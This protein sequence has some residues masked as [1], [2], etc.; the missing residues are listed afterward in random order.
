MN[1]PPDSVPGTIVWIAPFYNRSGF[2]VGARAIVSHLYRMGNRVRVV[3]VDQV[4]PGIDDCDMALIKSLEQTP[5]VPPITTVISHVPSNIWRQLK[6]PE[7]N[8]RIIATTVFDCAAPHSPA[9][10]EMLDVCR[11]MD[12]VWLHTPGERDRF[13]E[14][15]FPPGQVRTLIW[16]H[17]WIDNP[18]IPESYPEPPRQGAPFRFLSIAIFLPRRRWDT[19]I[20]AY[21]EEFKDT[22]D[23]EL[24]LKVSYP[25]WH[26]KP[27]KP[28]NDLFHLI[29]SLRKKTR[30]EAPIIID[31]DLGTRLEILRLVDSCNV[32]IST[33]TAPT[34]P[35]FEAVARR[36]LPITVSGIV[37]WPQ[38][39]ALEIP[40]D[41]NAK[42]PLT[43]EMLEYQPNHIGLFMPLLQ[44]QD[45]RQVLRQAY[46]MPLEERRS[47]A[48]AALTCLAS[49]SKLVRHMVA[50]IHDGWK[51]KKEMEIQKAKANLTVVWEGSQLVRHSLALV[52][53]Q[54]CLRLIDEGYH[55]QILPFEPDE[56]DPSSN[57]Q[58]AKIAERS[59]HQIPEKVDIYVRHRWPP[60]FNPPAKGHWVMMQPW[61][62]GSLPKELDRPH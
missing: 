58:L 44:V 6:L 35:N 33:D 37:A 14:A 49:P 19:L 47:R 50:A 59:T 43:Q 5:L 60:D 45:V 48:A 26:P 15:G 53:R 12:Q 9:P 51:F 32:Y 36:R 3:S 1:G 34:A 42:T 57:A 8:L 30:S 16:P 54:I 38:N 25:A 22:Q 52:N 27:G 20:E 4:E 31:E 7:P 41:P 23:V 13:L 40:V 24:Y 29:T 11:H 55:I 28:R 10:A 39:T 18:G 61:E 2:G 62:F 46:E 21:L 56:I 17:H